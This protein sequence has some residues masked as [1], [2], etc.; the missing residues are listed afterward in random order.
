[1]R[2]V[3]IDPAEAG[4]EPL[5]TT[6][7]VVDL[8]CV[9]KIPGVSVIISLSRNSE[10]SFRISSSNAVNENLSDSVNLS[11]VGSALSSP[12]TKSIL[13]SLVIVMSS[14]EGDLFYSSS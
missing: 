1:M 10:L 13:S 9:R 6:V 7:T 4:L 14:A 5:R 3:S 12:A 2:E 8:V 11:S